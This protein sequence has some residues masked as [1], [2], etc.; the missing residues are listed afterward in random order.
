MK[1]IVTIITAGIAILAATSA[2]ATKPSER[3]VR[4]YFGLAFPDGTIVLVSYPDDQERP[5][6]DV[7]ERFKAAW[8][9][10]NTQAK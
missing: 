3:T 8:Q 4:E 2:F 1:R 9:W 5:L 10:F 6:S 7:Q